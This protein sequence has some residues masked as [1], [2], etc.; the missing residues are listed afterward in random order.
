MGADKVVVTEEQDLLMAINKY[1]DNRGVDIVLDGLG[2]P[3]M[4]MLGDVLAPR[5]S[6]ILYG[7]QGGNQTPFP[8]CAAFQKNIQFFVHCVGNFTGKPELGIKQDEEA[9]KRALRD[10]NQMT[11]DRVLVPQI[12]KVFSFDQIVDAHR[13]MDGCPV[14]G[15]VVVEVEPA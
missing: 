6:L 1:T 9:V 11:A 13:M 15:R 2:G 8:A 12:T 4:S 3:Q 7:L 10:I 5:G 14:G